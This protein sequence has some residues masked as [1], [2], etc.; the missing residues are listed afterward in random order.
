MHDRIARNVVG[1]RVDMDGHSGAGLS[2]LCA[3]HSVA[4][5]GMKGQHNQHIQVLKPQFKSKHHPQRVR[6]LQ[7]SHVGSQHQ[8]WGIS[9]WEPWE[10][11]GGFL[12]LREKDIKVPILDVVTCVLLLAD[13]L[14]DIDVVLTKIEEIPNT[15]IGHLAEDTEWP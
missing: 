7:P 9:T 3:W 4:F 6:I 11:P 15:Y 14:L 13:F 12:V 8:T 10:A 1:N 2:E 5:H